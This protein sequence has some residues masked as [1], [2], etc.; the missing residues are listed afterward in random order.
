[1]YRIFVNRD[2]FCETMHSDIL[3]QFN[4]IYEFLIF[5]SFTNLL[6]IAMKRKSCFLH[7]L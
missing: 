4:E 6:E 5:F 7:A 3:S 1:M 2:E